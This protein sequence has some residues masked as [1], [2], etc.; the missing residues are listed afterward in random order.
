[1]IF[2]NKNILILNVIGLLR[3]FTFWV[4]TLDI[5]Y[6]LDIIEHC[7]LSLVFLHSI[8]L[9]GSF[10][11]VYIHPKYLD[12]DLYDKNLNIIKKRFG[13]KELII[14]DIIFHWLS[15]IIL[16]LFISKKKELKN[17]NLMNILIPLSYYLFFNIQKVYKLERIY[18]FIILIIIFL[19]IILFAFF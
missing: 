11:F 4:I 14:F 18:I 12:I 16:L 13:G 7:G 17:N 8:V 6:Y 19:F 9:L 5:L 10:I 2:E 3:Y 15:F 1:M